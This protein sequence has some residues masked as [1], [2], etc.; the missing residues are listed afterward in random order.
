MHAELARSRLVIVPGLVDEQL[1]HTLYHVL[2]LRSWRGEVKHDRQAPAADSHWGDATLDAAL[3]IL[4]VKIEEVSGCRL[5]PTYAYARLYFQGDALARHRDR[6]SCQIAAT[7]HLGATGGRASPIWFE[8]DIAVI[9]R[10][11]DAVVYLGDSI[12]HWREPFDG[13]SF[14]QLFLN[15][16][17]ADGVRA[18]LIHDGRRGAFP[19]SLTTPLGVGMPACSL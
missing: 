8:P 4:K 6:A 9:Q 16:V 5:L 14:G 17:F 11:G 1:A 3:L 13:E 18:D 15:Y 10:P 19:P 7:I 2:L 12:D